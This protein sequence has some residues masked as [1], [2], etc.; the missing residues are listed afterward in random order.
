MQESLTCIS[1]FTVDAVMVE[2]DYLTNFLMLLQEGI[3]GL[4]A[5]L[6]EVF[7]GFEV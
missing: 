6:K 2:N 5:T 4:T 7:V 3:G 1:H